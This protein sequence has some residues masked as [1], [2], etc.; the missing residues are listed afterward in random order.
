MSNDPKQKAISSYTE[1]ENA[2]QHI[3]R[4][5][6]DI[7]GEPAL[8]LTQAF[9]SALT[10][11]S[12]EKMMTYGSPGIKLYVEGEREEIERLAKI[13]PEEWQRIEIEKM[14]EA[15]VKR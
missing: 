3:H 1:L 9:F 15:R 14:R 11:G 5:I 10:K 2:V 7:D 13:P 12:K 6:D 4:T 8:E